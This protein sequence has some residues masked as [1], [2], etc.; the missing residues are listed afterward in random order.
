M[1]LASEPSPFACSR[2]P[3]SR[4][5][6]TRRESSPR[7]QRRGQPGRSL[8]LD[9]VELLVRG[10]VA[11]RGER[12]ARP[13]LYLWR[14]EQ[15]VDGL[16]DRAREAGYGRSSSR[17]TCP[18]SATAS[19]RCAT[20]SPSPDASTA[21]LSTAPAVRPGPTAWFACRRGR[22]FWNL[23]D[24]V[25]GGV[26]GDPAFVGPGARRHLGGGGRLMPACWWPS[27]VKASSNRVRG[28][29]GG[30]Q[31]RRSSDAVCVSAATE[32]ARTA[33]SGC[34]DVSRSRTSA[35]P[36]SKG[37]CSAVCPSAEKCSQGLP[38]EAPPCS[39][40]PL[41]SCLWP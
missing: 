8:R 38:L 31:V 18:S 24:V 5:S 14:S 32:A 1:V 21:H 29:I 25:P 34:L 33:A 16:A 27:G 28:H 39:G 15:V 7:L 11:R 12:F 17:S 40:R 6:S 23:V 10:E 9:R 13:Q 22:T 37:R 35:M 36:F 4:V 19:G 2:R 26:A 41:G 20:A 30:G 3:A